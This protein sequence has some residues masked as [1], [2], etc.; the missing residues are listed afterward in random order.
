VSNFAP[1]SAS[2]ASQTTPVTL[3]D[4]KC[5]NIRPIDSSDVELER[6]FITELSPESRRFRFLDTMTVPSESLLRQLTTVDATRDAALGAIDPKTERLVGV[7]RFS[8]DATGRAEVAIVISDDWQHQGLGSLL[9]HRIIELAQARGIREL[10][11]MD[12]D[13]NHVMRRFARKLGFSSH[14]DPD[15]ATQVIYSL[16]LH[17]TA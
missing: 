7:A 12:S 2:N 15:D 16:S 17:R 4:G 13:D 10:Y 9:A 3:P 5:I 1:A 8:S 11:S 14:I 6:R